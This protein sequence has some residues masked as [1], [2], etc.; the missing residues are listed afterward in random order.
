MSEGK[1]GK[2]RIGIS[3]QRAIHDGNPI[4]GMRMLSGMFRNPEFLAESLFLQGFRGIDEWIEAA[5]HI[6]HGDVSDEVISE[7]S[8]LPANNDMKVMLFAM[9]NN[10]HLFSE[11]R[12]SQE[13][14]TRIRSCMEDANRILKAKWDD[15][16]K[17]AEGRRREQE[18]KRS[19]PHR[20]VLKKYGDK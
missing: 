8:D 15:F 20:K 1:N 2:G 3:A 5:E 12:F 17:S 13:C 16:D 11:V 4:E 18:F 6:Q 19:V 14:A 10:L 7:L 9:R